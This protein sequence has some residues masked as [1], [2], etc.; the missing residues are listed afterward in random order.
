MNCVHIEGPQTDAAVSHPYVL[1]TLHILVAFVNGVRDDVRYDDNY[2]LATKPFS[3]FSRRTDYHPRL[4]AQFAIDAF[5][6]EMQPNRKCLPWR[7]LVDVRY[8]DAWRAH[9]QLVPALRPTTIWAVCQK[10]LALHN[11]RQ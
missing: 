2:R 8:D 11:K 5:A 10:R 7:A 1:Y 6:F 9:P 3:D 4:F